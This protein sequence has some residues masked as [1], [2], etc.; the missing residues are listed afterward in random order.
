L[1]VAY[2]DAAPPHFVFIRRPYPA[3]GCSDPIRSTA[4]LIRS[5]QQPVV[6]ENDMSPVADEQAPRAANPGDLEVTQFTLEGDRIDHHPVP[7]DAS[8]VGMEN[9]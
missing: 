7:D 9:P 8:F 1:E 3:I 6:F 2:P 5:F 4:F